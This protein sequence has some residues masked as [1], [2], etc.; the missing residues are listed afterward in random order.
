[1]GKIINISSLRKALL[2]CIVLLFSVVNTEKAFAQISEQALRVHWILILS[3][4]VE[5]PGP[6]IEEYSIG[7]YGYNAPEYDTLVKMLSKCRIKGKPVSALHFKRVK[8][9][10][11]THILYVNSGYNDELSSISSKIGGDSTLVITYSVPE[12]K[13]RQYFMINLL[14]KG[15][16]NQFEVNSRKAESAGLTISDKVLAQGGTRVDLITLVDNK[17]KQL[18]EKENMLLLQEMELQKKEKDITTQ[19]I[20]NDIEQEQTLMQRYELESKEKEIVQQKHYADSLTRSANSLQEILIH[21][22]ILLEKQEREIVEK[23]QQLN[24]STKELENQQN[25]IAEREGQIEE[26]EK[27]LNMQAGQIDTQKRIIF[28]A[29]IFAII[30]FILVVLTAV[31]NASRKR[32][33]R[34]LAQLNDEVD[35]QKDHIQAQSQ[36]LL[37]INKELEKLSIVA[38]QTDNGVM[39]MDNLGNIE[40]VNRGFSN[41]YGFTGKDLRNESKDSLT[42]FYASNK[43]ILSI[44]E[45]CLDTSKPKVFECEIC[46]KQGKNIWVQSTLTPILDE[47]NEI[48]RLV[49]I[50]TDITQIKEQEYAILQQG[51]TLALQRDELAQQNEFISE[52]NAHINTSLTYA[53]TIQETVMPLEVNITKYFKYFGI[54]I[55]LQIVSGDFYWFTRV[56]DDERIAFTAAVDCT[57]HGVPGAFMCMIAT[58]LLSEIIVEHRVY[59]TSEILEQLNVGIV[60]ALKQE[61]T[62]NNDSLEI[63]ICRFTRVSDGEYEMCFSGAKRPLYIYHDDTQEFETLKG[64]RKTIGGIM[65]K[66]NSTKFTSE[67]KNLRRNDKIYMTTDGFVNQF[68]NENR[69]YGSD[70]FVSLLKSICMKELPEEKQI[71]EDSYYAYK[72]EAEQ[73]DDVTVF[74]VQLI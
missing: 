27:R 23:Q 49:T 51:Q 40:W 48:S 30:I 52:Q 44:K 55:P 37:Q 70:K 18:Q 32:K 46:T 47:N 74:A 45:E 11:P 38:S 4:Y 21:N 73:N 3:E 25:R 34:Q 13:N 62:D 31:A 5:W 9:I 66:R 58:R 72:N 16:G 19:V 61:E 33:N 67:I 41:M 65:A 10:V 14:L 39:I 69:K 22:N 35:R 64:D 28:V 60:A 57:G 53:K 54:F 36:Q 59:E 68:D 12:G 15:R 71:L 2:C 7:V 50:D 1:M 63:C 29:I 24:T 42:G 43:D 20:A 26:H 56:P 17:D 6:E 8:E